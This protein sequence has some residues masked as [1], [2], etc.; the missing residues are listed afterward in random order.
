MD[1]PGGSFDCYTPLERPGANTAATPIVSAANHPDEREDGECDSESDPGAASSSS[2]SD[3]NLQRRTILQPRRKRSTIPAPPLSVPEQPARENVLAK[4]K[5]NI[6][7]ERIREEALTETMRNF[8]VNRDGAGDNRN[9]E[10]YDHTLGNR[11]AKDG[12]TNRLKRRSS[13]GGGGGGRDE[14]DDD[15]MDMDYG[16]GGKR[17]RYN[18]H[19]QKQSK[20]RNLED[21]TA[22]ADAKLEEVAT[23][24]ARNLKETNEALV[25]QVTVVCGR[26]FVEAIYKETQRIEEDGGMM[27]RGNRRRRTSGGVFFF[28]I[29]HNDEIGEDKKREAFKPIVVDSGEES[30]KRDE[31]IEEL[32]KTLNSH[33]SPKLLS[34]LDTIQTRKE[35]YYLSEVILC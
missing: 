5:Y 20:P 9:V 12:K 8:G 22:P 26:E 28:L 17:T 24:I 7:T 31:E 15:S 23:E 11:F 29:K 16:G 32:K 4:K 35:N 3:T 33:D 30:S 1:F 27:I 6:W 34:R 18:N 21:L 14:E 19:H 10:W 13:G 2:D 25:I